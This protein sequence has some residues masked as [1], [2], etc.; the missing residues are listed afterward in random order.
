MQFVDKK[1]NAGKSG[2]TYK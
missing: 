1:A 2:L